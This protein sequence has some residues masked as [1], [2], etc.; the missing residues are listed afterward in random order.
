MSLDKLPYIS[1]DVEGCVHTKRTLEKASAT[2]SSLAQHTGINNWGR[3][4]NCQNL[5]YAPQPTHRC[6]G[7]GQ[8]PNWIKVFQHNF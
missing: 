1:G 6:I 5:Q 2:N 8:K 3:L 7:R 4:V